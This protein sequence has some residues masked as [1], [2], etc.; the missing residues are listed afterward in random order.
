MPVKCEKGHPYSDVTHKDCPGCLRGDP[1]V[2]DFDGDTYNR[3]HDLK[4]L[5]GQN[6]RVSHCMKDGSWRTL[7]EI[8]EILGT[9]NSQ[10]GISARLRDL[11]KEKFG[12]HT[13]ER[14]RRGNAARGLF[15]YR[16]IVNEG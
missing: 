6:K 4:R 13:V 14:R 10:S 2:R 1:P 3:N 8:E 11:R 9:G 5:T 7:A 16:L 15:E 12:G